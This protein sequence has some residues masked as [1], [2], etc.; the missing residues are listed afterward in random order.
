MSRPG[1]SAAY[2][3]TAVTIHDAALLI[4]VFFT[5][6]VWGAFDPG[7]LAFAAACVG[8]AA[9]AALVARSAYGRPP[10]VIP[11]AVHLPALV[12]LGVS[13]VSAITSVSHHASEIELIRIAT[14]TALF[15]LVANR[16]LLP[17]APA[18][19]VSILLACSV[20]IA[21]FIGAPG[22][23]GFSLRLLVV[24]GLG[25]TCWLV[26]RAK[27]QEDSVSW[28]PA[29]LVISTSFVVALY[30]IREKIIASYVLSPPSPGWAIFS[31]FFNPN[32]LGGFLAMVLPLAVAAA[33]TARRG[34]RALWTVSALL[35]LGAVIPTYS[36][37]AMVALAVSMS[38][39]ALLCAAASARPRR[40]VALALGTFAL[41]ALLAG[42]AVS[43]SP[44][45]RTRV[46]GAL[47][48]DMH[49][50]MFRV[51]T[52]KATG[53]MAAAHPWLGTGPGTFKYAFPRYAIAGYVEAAH[54]NYLQIAAEQGF[55]GAAAFL[56]L[57]GAIIFTAARAIRRGNDLASRLPAIA[58]ISGIV[59]LLAHSLLD[60][61]WYIG[62]T[63]FAFYLMAG[64][65]AHYAHG[66]SLA[67]AR[68][69]EE[70]PS[71]RR[72]KHPRR[73]SDI[74]L[75]EGGPVHALLWP[76]TPLLRGLA[77]A[78]AGVVAALC[79]AVP[80][81]NSL[82]R[83]ALERANQAVAEAQKALARADIAAYGRER[84]A[85]L[86]HLIEAKSFDPGWGAPWESYGLM[87][88]VSGH[89]EEGV[90]AV[91]RAIRYEPTNY[92]PRYT[93][94]RL[95]AETG[96]LQ[97]AAAAYQEALRCFP[98]WTRALRMLAETY[99]RL[100]R[101]EQAMV[102]YRRMLE[103][104]GSAYNRYRA[105]EA[106]V[107]VDTDYAYAH[108]HLGRAAAG[109]GSFATALDRYNEALRVI[110]SYLEGGARKTDEM[111]RQI[112]QPREDRQAELQ[113]LEA[114]VRWRMADT[115]QR[116]GDAVAAQA[117]RAQARVLDPQV[118]KYIAAEDKEM[119]A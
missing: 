47:G 109:A 37:G 62:A 76:R 63:G 23:P 35:L 115:Y 33:L 73:E 57:I 5:P 17:A 80:L 27:E 56:W 87:W 71:R 83:K 110:R 72:R 52:W 12:F 75:D 11:N 85:A 67:A 92:K 108:Y 25:I 98:N 34:R 22:E 1:A 60:Y 79:V 66:R 99:Q 70:Q 78:G 86:Q 101:P 30:G 43:R 117:Q 89:K 69:T 53:L 45:L 21:V 118:D 44:S 74:S 97:E 29:A 46:V 7:G 81:R 38:C 100:G 18:R 55:P 96:Q 50:N 31:T 119:P 59:A 32:P 65:I 107:D 48:A 40:N 36:K 58:G 61:D 103:V 26:W 82:A 77:Y 9:M 42:A 15:L 28:L 41:A 51:L 91:E 6:L 24:V 8:T 4:A 19:S 116:Q 20:V 14:G 111:F 104:E 102:T 3:R 13:A 93:L 64:L 90:R 95:H 68:E 113:R 94:A 54:Q 10:A 16:A 49:S 39:F 105:L 88:G 112:G 114:M 2:A 84:D 106:D